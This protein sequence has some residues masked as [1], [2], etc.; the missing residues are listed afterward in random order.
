V[1]RALDEAQAKRLVAYDIM[2]ERY[3]IPSILQGELVDD[4]DVFGE[5]IC[6]E[7][8]RAGHIG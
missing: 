2:T 5:L 6:G 7:R 4:A 3:E 1:E 8:Q